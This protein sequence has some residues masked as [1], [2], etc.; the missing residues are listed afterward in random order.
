M[1]KV[2]NRR[3]FIAS[4]G[5]D[6]KKHTNQCRNITFVAIRSQSKKNDGKNIEIIL[7]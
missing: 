3:I 4:N 5:D 1:N 6:R 2:E 7:F